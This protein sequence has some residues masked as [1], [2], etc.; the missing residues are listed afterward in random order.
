MTYIRDGYL[1][2]RVIC[3]VILC[4]KLSAQGDKIAAHWNERTAQGNESAAQG[5][6]RLVK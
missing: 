4:N 6:E 2:Q 1:I 5:A 3:P